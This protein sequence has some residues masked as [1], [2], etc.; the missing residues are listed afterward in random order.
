[1]ITSTSK[2]TNAEEGQ[3]WYNN[4]YYYVYHNKEWLVETGESNN[5]STNRLFLLRTPQTDSSSY[6]ILWQYNTFG[7]VSGS[8][9]GHIVVCMSM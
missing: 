9:A 7:S 3:V 4:S 5:T 6:G 1:M 8:T 2:P